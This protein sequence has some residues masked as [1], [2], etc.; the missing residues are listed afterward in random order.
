[1][2]LPEPMIWAKLPIHV[3]VAAQSS[4]L[5]AFH[6]FE[7]EKKSQGHKGSAMSSTSSKAANGKTESDKKDPLKSLHSVL[8]PGDNCRVHWADRPDGDVT[9]LKVED[10]KIESRV[11]SE[12]GEEADKSKTK[13]LPLGQIY[14][15]SAWM[16]SDKRLSLST[17]TNTPLARSHLWICLRCMLNR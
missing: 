13:V 10:A 16:E 15:S 9:V 8:I 2:N 6:K 12:V 5:A 1:L 11:E 4:T 7:D 14:L 17:N 3:N